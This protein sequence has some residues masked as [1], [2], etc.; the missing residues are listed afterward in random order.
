MIYSSDTKSR[1]LILRIGT[2]CGMSL[3]DVFITQEDVK[4]LLQQPTPLVIR[5]F[6][7]IWKESNYTSKI[8]I[9]AM[10]TDFRDVTFRDHRFKISN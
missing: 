6:E 5:A 3:A 8:Q 1:D 10:S 4:Q 2:K 7:A 9:L